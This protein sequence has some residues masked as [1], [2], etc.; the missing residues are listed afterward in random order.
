MVLVRVP[1]FQWNTRRRKRR[2]HRPWCLFE[3]RCSSGTPVAARGGRTVRGACS[4]PA[5]PRGTP[6]HGPMCLC[7]SRIREQPATLGLHVCS[8]WNARAWRAASGSAVVWCRSRRRPRREFARSADRNVGGSGNAT[9]PGARSTWNRHGSSLRKTPAV[10]PK[11]PGL[12]GTWRPESMC[13]W[14]M[15]RLEMAPIGR[16]S[17]SPSWTT[18]ACSLPGRVRPGIDGWEHRR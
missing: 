8:T 2:T 17:H 11:T 18:T 16:R 15:V 12:T 10:G 7:S 9:H 14:P 4:S 6:T 5:V 13:R 1:L 3:S